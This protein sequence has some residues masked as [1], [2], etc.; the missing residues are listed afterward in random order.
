MLWDK[1]RNP[2]SSKIASKESRAQWKEK[3]QAK[4]KRIFSFSCLLTK[5]VNKILHHQNVIYGKC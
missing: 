4:K 1:Y 5:E 2:Y 3:G